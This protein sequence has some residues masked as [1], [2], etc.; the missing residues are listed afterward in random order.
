MKKLLFSVIFSLCAIPA[1]SSAELP[2]GGFNFKD[3]TTVKPAEAT[4]PEEATI[5]KSE[6]PSNFWDTTSP[7][8][9]VKKEV[10][11]KP[12]SW[13]CGAKCQ[14]A[15]SGEKYLHDQATN[16]SHLESVRIFMYLDHLSNKAGCILL[17]VKYGIN[18]QKSECRW[19]L[20]PA[21][22]QKILI[23]IGVRDSQINSM[24][25]NSSVDV[26][27][28]EVNGNYGK[29]LADWARL[30]QTGPASTIFQDV[31]PAV[32]KYIPQ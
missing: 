20:V 1:I 10:P 24:K 4:I 31:P 7:D 13:R 17:E 29:R 6:E 30:I 26:I 19:S 12:L 16:N 2:T 22:E 3:W 11:L 25:N 23:W 15:D 18:T 28:K 9:E 21:F 27:M 32:M 14:A 5:V 8:T